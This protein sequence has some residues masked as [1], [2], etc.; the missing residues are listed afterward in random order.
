MD[1]DKPVQV[2]ARADVMVTVT[3]YGDSIEVYAE[4]GKRKERV[5]LLAPCTVAELDDLIA[6]V[7]E[8]V[9]KP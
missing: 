1:A 8:R 4:R 7:V 9:N 6:A 2:I 5:S 3:G